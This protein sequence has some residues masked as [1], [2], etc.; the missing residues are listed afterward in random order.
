MYK[1]RI[2]PANKK[3]KK[4]AKLIGRY[5]SVA[6]KKL[7]DAIKIE[8]FHPKKNLKERKKAYKE[9]ENIILALKPIFKEIVKERN[10]IFRE[11]RYKNY[12]DF[13]I[14][15]KGIPKKKINLFFNKADKV[16]KDINQNLPLSNKLPKWYWSEFNIPDALDLVKVPEY[17][18]PND[19]YRLAKSAFPEIEKI[20]PR[21]KI[22]K[23]K[24]FNPAARFIKETKSV[25]IE[26]STKP[27]IYNA[28][29][30]VHELG[31]AISFIKLAEKGIDPLSKSKYWHETEAYK[32]V[33]QFEKLCLE[34][35]VKNASRGSI[36]GDFL[37]TFFEYKIYNNPDQDFDKVYAKAVNRCY[38][39]A[40]QERNPFY[41]LENSLIFRPCSSVLNSVVWAELL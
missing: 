10:K 7:I 30:F 37:T 29:D 6:P 16:I 33:L 2:F 36:L 11:D 23:I 24:D 31:H 4:L 18:I 19:I 5:Y 21:I 22:E 12:F 9:F 15:K 26:V 1:A 41:V 28:L 40:N 13:F 17:S 34:K 35:E 25:I 27:S 32:F 14:N 20:L 39:K 3:Q 38:P 8:I